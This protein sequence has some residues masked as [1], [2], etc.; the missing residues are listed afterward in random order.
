MFAAQFFDQICDTKRGLGIC[1][2]LRPLF[3]PGQ[4]PRV[5]EQTHDGIHQPAGVQVFLLDHAG[6]SGTFKGHGVV[7]LV[8]VCGGGVR[9]QN[10]S[11]SC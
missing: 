11:R 1:Q 4:L 10:L 9:N 3:H 8:L 2:I 7:Q 6:G 5:A